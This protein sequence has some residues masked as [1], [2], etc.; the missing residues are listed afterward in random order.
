MKHSQVAHGGAEV[1]GSGDADVLSAADQRLVAA[2]QCDGRAPAERLADV[3]GMSTREVHR[4]LRALTR[5]DV[6]RVRGRL[7]QPPD[8]GAVQLRIR[9]LRGRIEQISSALA[10]REDIPFVD[11]SAAGDEIHAVQFT[12][13]PAPHNRLLLQQLPATSAVTSVEAQTVLHAFRQ[14]HEWRLDVLDPAERQALTPPPAA[15][16]RREPDETDRSVAAALAEDGRL[17]ASAVAERTGHPASTVRRRLTALLAGGL[18]R[19]EVVVDPRRLGLFVDANVWLQLPPDRLDAAGR[20]L[21][22][23]PAVH[24]ALAGTGR[25]N[26]S[27]A[28]WLPDTAALYR[29]LSEDLTGLGVTAV[30][31]FLVGRAV[32]RPG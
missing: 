13:G 11:M 7:A 17:S 25:N 9:V 4:R 1:R 8:L 14:A 32:K 27:L 3:L 26:L 21:A 31:T 20:T 18:L 22:A 2:L 15:S 10:A 28:L 16:E 30:E 5:Q 12:R 29:F 24:G 19:T 6:V 23:H